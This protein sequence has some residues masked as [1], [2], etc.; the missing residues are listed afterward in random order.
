MNEKKLAKIYQIGHSSRMISLWVI[1][2]LIGG[3]L[4]IILNNNYELITWLSIILI[5]FILAT[6]II[7]SIIRKKFNPF[8]PIVIVNLLYFLYF[9]FAPVNDLLTDNT[10]FFGH[11]IAPAISL[12]FIYVALG[13][14]SIIIGYYLSFGKTVAKSI[15]SPKINHKLSIYYAIALG[16]FAFILLSFWIRG[17]G[18]N[19]IRYLTFNQ[20][21]S[22]AIA[23][24]DGFGSSSFRNYL[25]CTIDWFI[26]SF[27]ILYAFIKRKR[28]ILWCF[29]IAILIIFCTI[30]FRFRILILVL[31]P[32]VY[33]FLK[34]KR[35]NITFRF[36]VIV[37]IIIF[38]IVSILGAVRGG[39][40]GG[41]M[42]LYPLTFYSAWN[43]F[44]SSLAVYQPFLVMIKTIPKIHDYYWGSSYTY[45]FLQPIPRA[46]WPDRPEA[47]QH[48]II[49]TIFGSNEPVKSGVAFVNIGEFYANF[50]LAGIIL[51][52]F[53]F[54]IILRILFEYLRCYPENEWVRILYSITL[55]FLIQIVSRGYF[56]QNM[57]E[58]TFIIGPVIIGMLLSSK[59]KFIRR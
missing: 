17:G 49:R 29:F 33:H 21:G 31:A 25:G 10:I 42:A 44:T 37:I 27:V 18:S 34:V 58:F 1:G 38:L 20:L 5:L 13:L 50:G 26:A 22:S 30:G 43:A 40:R 45:I 28:K 19:W 14:V 57:V 32:L 59:F 7:I 35:R 41:E 2:I 15:P 48:V 46:L 24:Y 11:D 51:G 6:P 53:F 47:P 4:P 23:E 3:L 54:G 8:S 52:M 9:V 12:G 16:V 36:I 55:P 56:V 39:F